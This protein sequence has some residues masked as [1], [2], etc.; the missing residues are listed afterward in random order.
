MFVLFS[1]FADSAAVMVT[2]KSI[3]LSVYCITTFTSMQP[4]Q[5]YKLN[6]IISIF[7]S[8]S[9]F[10]VCVH[11]C[12]HV[13]VFTSGH[14]Y[15]TYIIIIAVMCCVATYKYKQLCV[16][17]ALCY[18]I[19]LLCITCSFHCQASSKWHWQWWW[20]MQ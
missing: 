16:S 20:Y 17:I 13:S 12:V 19:L 18:D 11:I 9:S 6:R 7:N 10:L 8:N 4:S 15:T 2:S 1:Q 14:H 3:R 5:Q